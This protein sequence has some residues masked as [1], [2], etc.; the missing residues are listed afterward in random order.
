M[1]DARLRVVIDAVDQTS[2]TF[3][4]FLGRLEA[5]KA[6]LRSSGIALAAFG[7][8]GSALGIKMAKAAQDSETSLNI[9]RNALGNVGVSYAGV[10][11]RIDAVTNALM[12]K[13]GV[14]DEA[15]R[16]ALASLVAITG[17]FDTALQA[18]PL[19]LDLAAAKGTDVETA[20]RAIGKALMGSQ[21]ALDRFDVS[22]REGTTQSEIFAAIL[23][24]YGGRAEA[25]KTPIMELKL[26]LGEMA[27]SIGKGLLPIIRILS[28]ATTT[29]A[30]AFLRL[31]GPIQKVI[32]A[33]AAV[34]VVASVMATISGA[35]LVFISMLPAMAAG[36]ALITGGMGVLLPLLLPLLPI[37]IAISLAIAAGIVIW[38]NWGTILA[39]LKTIFHATFSFIM[40]VVEKAV[41][42]IHS[43]WGLLVLSLMGPL[44]WIILLASRWKEIWEGMGRIVDVSA[45][46]IKR[47][48]GAFPEWL[49]TT[50]SV[51]GFILISSVLGP[52]PALL[53]ALI[54][55]FDHIK[56][57]L[58]IF[59]SAW[60]IV[61]SIRGYL[62]DVGAAVISAL[63]AMARKLGGFL[64][65][66]L[67]SFVD[68]W[69][70]AQTVAGHL[71][72]FL[73]T[74][75]S[76]L[77]DIAKELAGFVATGG[78]FLFTGAW[79]ITKDV[80]G[81]LASLLKSVA[82]GLGDIGKDLATFAAT[83]ALFLF[84]GAWDI[85]EAVGGHIATLAKTVSTKLGDLV[86]PLTAF[87]TEGALF[88]FKNAWNMGE[89]VGGFI[90]DMA[91]SVGSALLDVAKVLGTFIKDQ[92]GPFK[93][94]WDI[95][96]DVTGVYIPDLIGKLKTALGAVWDKALKPFI[97]D[98]LAPFKTAWDIAEDVAASIK[99][100][101][102]AVIEP[103]KT[104]AASIGGFLGD[105]GLLGKL[106]GAFTA[107]AKPIKDTFGGLVD[108][109]QKAWDI[110]KGI[111]GSVPGLS[112]SGT[113]A[114]AAS[115]PTFQ[116][117]GTMQ[118][119]GMA[120]VG[121]RGPEVVALPRGASVTP[122]SN[123]P[124]RGDSNKTITINL[125]VDGRV[126][127][128]VTG[129]LAQFEE[130]VRGF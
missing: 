2:A 67:K 95:V 87:F 85:T 121:E 72:G 73:K 62:N 1:A 63:G 30:N 8:I 17:D 79:D 27:E 78:L 88:M 129:R 16:S 36:F 32:A 123:A 98:A 76:G 75:I 102:E 115:I 112:A 57:A 3:G 28:V 38:K 26:A 86:V 48:W 71:G 90:V 104:I 23:A 70:V 13:T 82:T 92:L 96:A 45:G 59:V 12:K 117:G 94:A 18:L 89:A 81:H 31:P 93:A 101:V 19:A 125:V 33:I 91:K 109:L 34:A 97:D 58:G 100:V 99:G 5:S 7:A 60:N 22:I 11:G 56:K 4:G 110:I 15:Q 39:T 64:V 21:G 24:Q 69:N 119:T 127:S 66:T 52:L 41:N 61:K 84:T 122:I 113:G 51:I 108:F 124:G 6:R 126:L 53:I 65:D 68:A 10:Q 37:I 35:V 106:A 83:G 107:L 25:A 29:I 46:S 40:N 14:A 74:V 47:I 130:Q 111:I 118:R 120:L 20:A 116:F 80:S 50:L 9:L 44:G 55:H 103:L 105:D 42:F 43:K 128:S 77:A 49:Q 114:G 54:T